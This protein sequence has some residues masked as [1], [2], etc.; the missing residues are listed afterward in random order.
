MAL[1][2][3]P[4][5]NNGFCFDYRSEL[6]LHRIVPTLHFLQT[7]GQPREHWGPAAKTLKTSIL[8]VIKLEGYKVLTPKM[9]FF[10]KRI[11]TFAA[12]SPFSVSLLNKINIYI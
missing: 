11:I 7:T 10:K 9:F 8:F 12:C 5:S 2:M 6:S 1:L 3:G 4:L